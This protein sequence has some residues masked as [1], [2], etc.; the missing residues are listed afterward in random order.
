MSQ[1]YETSFSLKTCEE[2]VDTFLQLSCRLIYY[3]LPVDSER[4]LEDLNDNFVVKRKLS[5]TDMGPRKM[6]NTWP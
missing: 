1:R 3:L 2:M 4:L 5:M 6:E